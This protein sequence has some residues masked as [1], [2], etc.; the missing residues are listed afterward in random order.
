MHILILGNAADPHA[1]HVKEAIEQVGIPAHYFDTRQFPGLLRLSWFPVDQ[2]GHLRLPTGEWLNMNDVHSVFW[3]SLAEF[4]V[5]SLPDAHQHQIALKDCESTLR[6][7]IQGSSARWVNSWTA[8][9]FHKEKP[10]QLARV[11]TLG[12]SIPATLISNDPE[13]VAAFASTYKNVIFK[14]VYGGAHT[15]F[16]TEEHLAPQR[17][18]MVLGI[19]PVTLQEFIPGTNLRS[20]VIGDAVFTAELRSSSIDFRAD[21]RVQL[22]STDL[23]PEVKEQCRT[24][25][26][27]LGLEWTAIDWRL[28]PEGRYVFLEA[29]PSPMFLHFERQTGFP[30]TQTLVELLT[31]D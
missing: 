20:Y 23:P 2:S 15:R 7:F 13:A 11:H 31:A 26:R 8:Y 18:N 1:A 14:P 25:A 30:I 12:V 17:L 28:S 16:V 29:N 27:A 10:R 3:R 6:S 21:A 5:P 19:S 4:S 22:I 9:Q 24:I